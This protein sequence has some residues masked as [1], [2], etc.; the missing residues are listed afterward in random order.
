MGPR[1]LLSIQGSGWGCAAGWCGGHWSPRHGGV[2][3]EQSLGKA[4]GLGLGALLPR[5]TSQQVT[6]L[7]VVL[8]Y[9]LASAARMIKP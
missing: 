4:W 3:R 6:P 8:G 1:P 7:T 2:G 9:R 5:L